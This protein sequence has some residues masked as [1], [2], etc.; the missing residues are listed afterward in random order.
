MRSELHG[1][2][3]SRWFLGGCAVDRVAAVRVPRTIRSRACVPVL[4]LALRTRSDVLTGTWQPR[5][6]NLSYGSHPLRRDLSI[7][8][9]CER[10]YSITPLRAKQVVAGFSASRT[11]TPYVRDLHS[12]PNGCPHKTTARRHELCHILSRGYSMVS[13]GQGSNMTLVCSI[14]SL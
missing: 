7:S 2:I 8:E 10:H 5:R 11:P 3:S 12:L 6:S 14:R 9:A 13:H 4:A 1:T